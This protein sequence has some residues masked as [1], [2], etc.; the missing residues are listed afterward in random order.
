MATVAA[1]TPR[2]QFKTIGLVSVGHGLSHFYLIALPP[3]FPLLKAEFDTSW[4]ALGL[5]LSLFSVATGLAQIPA[6]LLVDRVGGRVVLIWGLAVYAVSITLAG[7]AGSYWSLMVL[8][9]CAGIGNAAFHPADYRILSTRI[10]K[11]RLGRTFSVHIFAGWVGWMAA[12]G[13]M[14]VLATLWSWRTALVVVGL[15]GLLFTLVMAWQYDA[16]D[17][18]PGNGTGAPEEADGTKGQAPAAKRGIALFLSLP[19]LMLWLFYLLISTASMGVQTFSVVS[20]VTLY[21]TNLTLANAALTGFFV[22]GGVGV[23]LGGWAADRTERPEFLMLL[24]ITASAA[25][26]AVI[27]FPVFPA[28]ATVV[29]LSLAGLAIAIASPSRDVI[30]TRIAPA[31][32]IG[33]VFGFLSTGFAAGLAVAPVLFGWINDLGRPDVVFWLVAVIALAAI[34]TLYGAR[35]SDPA[36]KAG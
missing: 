21:E 29:L 10:A 19:I 27:G 30:V 34:V 22:G 1:R 36:R 11:D 7:F 13:A 25:L 9:L 2:A 33:T 24:A 17:D 4:A 8:M 26:I 16:L 3:L 20:I 31:E 18:G 6:G 15:A 32:S 23:L 28:Y 14:L 12:P 5:I 35:E